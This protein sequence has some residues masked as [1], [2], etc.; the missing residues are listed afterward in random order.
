MGNKFKSA[1]KMTCA[2][3]LKPGCWSADASV[4]LGG[5][6]PTSLVG[7][8]YSPRMALHEMCKEMND[9][10]IERERGETVCMGPRDDC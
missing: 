1:G 9:S 6:A 3:A 8:V 5:T 2:P 4:G 10:G 7:P